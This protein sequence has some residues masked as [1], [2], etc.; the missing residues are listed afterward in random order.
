MPKPTTLTKR[1]QLHLPQNHALRE[2]L[3]PHAVDTRTFSPYSGNHVI[4][5]NCHLTR[6][7]WNQAWNQNKGMPLVSAMKE[8]KREKERERERERERES[9]RARERESERARER[10]S[11]RARERESERARERESERAR[12][13]ERER[14][15]VCHHHHYHHRH[16]AIIT[17]VIMMTVSPHRC[18]G[19]W[20]C[21]QL[22]QAEPSG[23]FQDFGIY[24]STKF[25]RQ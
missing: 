3:A 8:S 6:L 17:M 23:M 2:Q 14:E 1:P 13:R 7:A 15:R 12:E 9:E 11:E 5:R 16:L 25:T 20:N 10:E 21:I 22:T 18:I 19:A 4:S 24:L